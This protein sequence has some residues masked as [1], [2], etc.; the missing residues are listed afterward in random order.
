MYLCIAV[1]FLVF[2]CFVAGRP[3]M[4][5]V[6]SRSL[7]YHSDH[8]NITWT[9]HSFSPISQY[10]ISYRKVI[11]SISGFRFTSKNSFQFTITAI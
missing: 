1:T 7:G 10:K 2:G 8:Y 6:T 11:V 5:N 9:V 4:A 3:N